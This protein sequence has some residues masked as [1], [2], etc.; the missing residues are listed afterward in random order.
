MTGKRNKASSSS[1]PKRP[2]QSPPSD[3]AS[4]SPA[5]PVEIN[6]FPFAPNFGTSLDDSQHSPS[7]S[8]DKG[9]TVEISPLEPEHAA[10][11]DVSIAAIQSFPFTF[12]LQL[13]SLLSKNFG[14]TSKPIA[15]LATRLTENSPLFPLI[16]AKLPLK[17]QAIIKLS[18]D[19]L[20]SLKSIGLTWHEPTEVSFLCHRCG[21]PGC[22]PD[23][24]ASSRALQRPSCPWSS[25]DKLPAIDVPP[26]MD[27]QHITD[28]IT[29]ILEE[30][31]YFT[32]EFTD[33]QKRVKWL[34]DQHSSPP[35]PRS[36]QPHVS[37]PPETDS[38]DQGWDN[39]ET[40][41]LRRFSDNL[42]DFSSPVLSQHGPNFI[43]QSH[44]P[45]PPQMSLIPV[46]MD[47]NNHNFSPHPSPLIKFGQINVNGLCFPVRQQ[48]LLNFFLHSSFGVLSL[49]DT[50]FSPAN[51]KNIFKIEQFQHNFRSYWACS[52]S[53]RP[54]DG[55]G[56]LLSNPLHK[57]VQA[58]NPWEGRLLK[59][60]FFF[61]QTKISIISLYNPPSGDFNID[62]I[63]HS[64][65]SSRYFKLLRLFTSCY[66]IDHQAYSS[67][68]SSP[69]NTYFYDSG[70]FRLDYIWSSS[71][72]PAPGLFSQVVS[73]P[74]L[75]DC[76]FTDYHTLITIFDFSTCLA[77][78][79]K[80]RVKQKKEERVV[81]TYNYTTEAHWTAFSFDTLPNLSLLINSWTSF[82]FHL[83]TTRPSHPT[84][85]S[86][87]IL[88][89]PRQFNDLATLIPDY[90]AS[91]SI[92][93]Y[94]ALRNDYF[95]F[96]LGTFID[97]ALS[98][99]KCS[100]VL[101]RVLKFLSFSLTKG[102][103]SLSDVSASLYDPVLS[104]ISLQ[105]W[106]QVISSMP[107]NKASG[108]SKISYEM[109][110]H[111]SK[112]AL[113]FSLLLANSCLLRGDIPADWHEAVV[114]PI[115]KPY[116]F[117]A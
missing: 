105:K 27:W 31:T 106:S 55:V 68:N 29:I 43:A 82:Y 81:F 72:F 93:Y 95:S 54:H 40:S 30:I 15:K 80:S 44:I 116:D 25:N 69:D 76:L 96:S 32:T 67:I 65:Y 41:Y 14:P 111:L 56:I 4:T 117:N 60:D 33:L 109:L 21:R 42:M 75:S 71:G 23:K 59:I 86:Q 85:L 26:L 36:S 89:L 74:D 20:R 90:Y 97:S 104:P 78:L 101:D 57:H 51:A 102:I 113:E 100:I 77:I 63:A 62:T 50:Y 45:L 70:A 48:H 22:N 9:K 8:A 12:M 47:N 92:E 73:C 83:T 19:Y 61:Y 79:A 108:P 16:V 10:S 38:I 1:A 17:N 64:S 94:T 3:T 58:I 28:Q 35:I 98:V 2:A 53:S 7:N 5:S 6:V 34:E 103:Y 91:D 49:N 110:K 11:P 39:N 115:P 107:N 52:S 46:M 114:Y 13:R 37:L 112:D 88:A 66:F 87:M 84:Q 18:L 24:C 99:E